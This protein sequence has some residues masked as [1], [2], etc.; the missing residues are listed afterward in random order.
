MSL[1]ILLVHACIIC[2]FLEILIELLVPRSG[3]GVGHS[4]APVLLETPIL[5]RTSLTLLRLNDLVALFLL[6]ACLQLLHE[7]A[8]E[9]GPD[10]GGRGFRSI[11]RFDLY[12]VLAKG[13]ARVLSHSGIG[14]S[15]LGLLQTE[16]HLQEVLEVGK[17][18]TDKE[19]DGIG[20]D[21]EAK[22][23]PVKHPL[24]GEGSIGF[25]EGQL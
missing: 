25:L 16:K 8:L 5:L 7:F 14:L 6:L 1:N 22:G 13:G 21:K 3:T 4:Y 17:A 23:K 9:G 19:L 18:N 24:V 11:T 10:L 20:W 12:L 2:I 15:L